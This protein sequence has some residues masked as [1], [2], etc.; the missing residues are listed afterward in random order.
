MALGERITGACLSSTK[1]NVK[2]LDSDLALQVTRQ[3]DPFL[4]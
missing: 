1:K 4:T 3:P 2:Y